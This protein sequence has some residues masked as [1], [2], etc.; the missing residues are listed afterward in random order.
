M[1]LGG[2]DGGVMC[3]AT[4]QRDPLCDPCAMT[5]E[6]D[7]RFRLRTTT[8]YASSIIF[9]FAAALASSVSANII[10][11]QVALQSEGTVHATASWKYDNC[12]EYRYLSNVCL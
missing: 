3:P 11:E 4:S 12:G 9:L 10:P 7:T 8:M 6:R 5:S 2:V 1:P